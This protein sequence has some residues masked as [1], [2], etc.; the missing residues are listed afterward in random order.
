MC[1]Y[2]T[3]L[4]ARGA[5][6]CSGFLVG[7]FLAVSAFV[8]PPLLV[9]AQDFTV[10]LKVPKVQQLPAP[11][12][13][14]TNRGTT[15]I[16]IINGG[17]LAGSA[18]I[19]GDKG[20]GTL[21]VSNGGTL[22]TGPVT[23]A[24]QSGST[25]NVVVTGNGSTI[26]NSG[27]ITVANEGIG[28]LGVDNGGTLNTT[29]VTIGN[30]PLSNGIVAVDGKG[31]TINNSGDT[32]V[33]F[34][35]A[36]GASL[37]VTNGGV[38]NSKD[39]TIGALPDSFGSVVID[40]QGSQ[41]NN[42]GT[43][44]DSSGDL[45][46]SNGGVVT[47]DEGTTVGLFGTL[48]GNGTVTTPTLVNNGI[49]TP[50]TPTGAPATLTINGTYQ[51]TST[52]L[53]N[54]AV[55]GTQPLQASSLNVTGTAK[56]DGALGIVSTNNFQPVAGDC[57]QILMAKAVN[58]QFAQV[59]DTTR[60]AGLSRAQIYTPSNVTI[61]YLRAVGVPASLNFVS[62]TDLPTYTTANGQQ[63]PILISVFDPNLEQYT[64]LFEVGITSA[65]TQRFN[66]GARFDDIRAG[67]RGFVSNVTPAPPPSGKEV[68]EGKGEVSGKEAKQ[69]VPPSLQPTPEN[70]WGV[71]V[72]G[73]GDFVDVGDD[74]FVRGYDF[75]TGG[76]TVGLDYRILNNLV[77][78]LF[79]SYSQTWVDQKP[80]GSSNI[81][82]GLGGLYLG[83]FNGGF[84]GDVGAYGGYYSFDSTRQG[85]LGNA[86]GSSDGNE[87]SVFAD[88]GYDFHFGHFTVGPTASVQYTNVYLNGFTETGSAAPAR[89]FDDS[90]ESLRSDV[91]LRAS[92][93]FAAGR[94]TVR[95]FVR[96]AWEHEY[97][98]TGLPITASLVDFNEPAVT[99]FG[100][101][102]GHDSALIN[103]GVSVQWTERVSTYVSYDGQ[104]GRDRYNANGVSGG[105][106]FS[107]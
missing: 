39:T 102:L 94:I 57:F 22:N 103:A 68:V 44:D 67:S 32:T 2:K 36:A 92:Y 14:G 105:I 71:W 69:T 46:V 34:G 51:Q 31:S 87:W 10:T 30:Q 33:G 88:T 16:L 72:T 48:T 9:H 37:N 7:I 84:Y 41:L 11:I 49:V 4:S 64:S 83:Y 70:R 62:A 100:P 35:Q 79:G 38:V 52:G 59:F 53:L 73:F 50:G 42:S 12:N 97:K 89:I 74:N 65:N 66:I 26:N 19:A 93:D 63:C 3:D 5:R 29:G 86:T 54:I 40:G 60:S 45:H 98:Y 77:V 18:T 13:I 75:T 47:A 58:G 81:D 85:L 82:T 6:N 43:L 17:T 106:R 20:N 23:I 80:S 107:F 8:A 104:V 27:D 25:G 15:G 95:P 1:L 96:A 91:G 78:G 24:N 90:E 61:A 56:L 28:T 101:H 21:V 55:G 99:S 76:V